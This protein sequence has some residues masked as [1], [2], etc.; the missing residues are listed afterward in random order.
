MAGAAEAKVPVGCCLSHPSARGGGGYEVCLA[1]DSL[2]SR[3]LGFATPLQKNSAY[4]NVITIPRRLVPSGV[5]EGFQSSPASVHPAL[6]CLP[7]LAP[8]DQRPS[9]A[10]HN[11]LRTCSAWHPLVTVHPYWAGECPSILLPPSRF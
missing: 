2:G 4:W 7:L 8:K 5:S 6:L 1:Q 10:L 9:L 11:H 3:S